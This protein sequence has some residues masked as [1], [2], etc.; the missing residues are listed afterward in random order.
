MNLVDSTC[1]TDIV[2][3]TSLTESMGHELYSPIR[4]CYLE[5]GKLLMQFV[6][7]KYIKDAGDSHICQFSD[8]EAPLRFTTMLQQIYSK[9]NAINYA[10]I[11]A[12]ASISLGVIQPTDSDIFGSGVNLAARV[13]SKTPEKE[14]W[15]NQS[16]VE[17][18]T[19]VWES[20]KV[21]KYFFEMGEFELKG[22]SKQKLFSFN[23]ME[24]SQ[25]HPE[26]T[27][28]Q[29]IYDHLRNASVVFSNLSVEDISKP[30]TIIWPVV[31]RDT[32]NAIHRAQLEMIRLLTLLD[33]NVH[34][35]IANCGTKSNYSPKYAETF[36][37]QIERYAKKRYLPE[38]NFTLM[39]DLYKPKSCNCD[40]LHVYFQNILSEITLSDLLQINNK[41]YSDTVKETIK[42]S[43]S[44]D[45]LRPVLTI[46]S[47]MHLSREKEAKEIVVVGYDEKIQW[48]RSHDILDGRQRFGVLFNPILQQ[49]DGH[50]QRQQ[51]NWPNWYSSEMLFNDMKDTNLASWTLRL[52]AFIPSFPSKAVSIAGNKIG[53]NIWKDGRDFSGEINLKELAQYVFDGLLSI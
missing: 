38:F 52:H 48:E 29:H 34:V 7:G 33:W 31:P 28:A 11:Q 40:S 16:F 51:P 46:A 27:L 36:R 50:F 25:D 5:I 39:S 45:F 14:I 15:V 20:R 2:N 30:A 4:Q 44:I 49:N 53:P 43:A 32:V 6:S 22:V 1:F 18:I 9:Q 23:W 35:L 41:E 26:V 10:G 3:S 42:K 13:E 21:S 12:R 17:A 8:L 19:R 24:Y 47:V 37:A